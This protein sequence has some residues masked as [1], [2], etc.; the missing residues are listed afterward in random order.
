MFIKADAKHRERI[1]ARH[2]LTRRQLVAAEEA[3]DDGDYGADLWVADHRS[4]LAKL[5]S[6]LAVHDDPGIADGTV[7]NLPESNADTEVSLAFR[8]RDGAGLAA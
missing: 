6:M 7:V 3:M 8:Q 2:E 1:A 5:A 4:H